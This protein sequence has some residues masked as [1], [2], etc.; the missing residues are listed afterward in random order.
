MFGRHKSKAT[1]DNVEKYLSK[2]NP[3][4]V[5]ISGHGDEEKVCG[6]KDEPIFIFNHN[7]HFLKNKIV[8]I[9]ACG[10]GEKLGYSIVD[11][12]KAKA[13]I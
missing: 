2:K 5:F 3:K 11:N 12:G 10:S 7:E 4:F 1:K 13:F 6:H 9:V 8:Y